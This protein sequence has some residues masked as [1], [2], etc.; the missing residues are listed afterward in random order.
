MIETLR[1]R[2]VSREVIEDNLSKEDALYLIANLEDQGQTNLLMEEYF[3]EANRIG[4][5][6]DLHLPG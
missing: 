3:P 1:Y 2:V 4:R 6:P 5:N